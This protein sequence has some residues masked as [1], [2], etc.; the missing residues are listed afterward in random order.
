MNTK[1]E[2]KDKM[3]SSVSL[4]Y[5]SKDVLVFHVDLNS[6]GK[7]AEISGYFF[8]DCR[9]IALDKGEFNAIIK[10]YELP[11]ENSVI[12][13]ETA[14]HTVFITIFNRDLLDNENIIYV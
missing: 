14:K 13:G 3:I 8:D 9:G 12:Y 10:F 6:I 11:F 1:V 4:V 2:D 7:R 5:E